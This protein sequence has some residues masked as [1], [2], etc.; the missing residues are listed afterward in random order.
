MKRTVC[1]VMGIV[2][3]VLAICNTTI[4]ASAWYDETEYYTWID[5]LMDVRDEGRL[6]ISEDDFAII[7]RM[8]YLVDDDDEYI[9]AGR[10][11]YNPINGEQYC[12]VMCGYKVDNVFMYR[13]Y[14]MHAIGE[15]EDG[16]IISIDQIN[17]KLRYIDWE[18]ID[19]YYEWAYA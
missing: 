9:N 18:C 11:C 4:K 15:T 13:S 10:E 14:V 6:R 17:T 2:M 1:F 12:I 5:D 8:Y 16:Y 3:I 7:K 19:N